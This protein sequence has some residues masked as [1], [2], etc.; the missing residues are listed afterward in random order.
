MNTV[1]IQSAADVT[2]ECLSAAEDVF[3][4]WFDHG[5]GPIDWHD[6]WDRLERN[7]GWCITEVDSPAAIKI[8]R[9]VRRYR[10]LP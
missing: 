5:T 9:H 10:S 1:E 7:H 2:A 4:G 8:Q 6:F 3:T